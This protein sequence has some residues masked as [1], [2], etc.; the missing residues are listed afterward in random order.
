MRTAKN[1]EDRRHMMSRGRHEEW[2]ASAILKTRILSW[3]IL[4]PNS[5]K[6]GAQKINFAQSNLKQPSDCRI[7]V[8]APPVSCLEV[9]LGKIGQLVN[10]RAAAWIVCNCWP[11]CGCRL[12]HQHRIAQFG[13]T[14]NYAKPVPWFTKWSGII[15]LR[16]FRRTAITRWSYCLK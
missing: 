1:M 3:S 8:S 12:H 5:A 14:H 4:K 7:G 10:V 13:Q 15:F 2:P 9:G 6:G 11:L 16:S